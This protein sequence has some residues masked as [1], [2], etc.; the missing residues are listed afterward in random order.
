MFLIT[1][2][3]GRS[4]AGC[5]AE[6]LMPANLS[7]DA[8][9]LLSADKITAGVMRA[10]AGSTNVFSTHRLHPTEEVRREV[11][12]FRQELYRVATQAANDRAAKA[13]GSSG[14]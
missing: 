13:R 6:V 2:R 11:R 12:A 9:D 7:F 5:Y 14:E 10:D 8:Q 3:Y 1:S 4:P